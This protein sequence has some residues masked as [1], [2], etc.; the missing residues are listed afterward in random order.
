MLNWKNIQEL[1]NEKVSYET[2]C[3]V[4]YYLCTKGAKERLIFLAFVCV[5]ISMG[6]VNTVRLTHSHKI[7]TL[8]EEG[9]QYNQ[10]LSGSCPY[11]L[12]FIDFFQVPLVSIEITRGF[13]TREFYFY[14]GLPFG[15]ARCARALTPQEQ[16]PARTSGSQRMTAPDSSPDGGLTLKFVLRQSL[17]NSRGIMAS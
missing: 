8:F 11:L 4:C 2:V 6:R 10:L 15:Q 17:K 9:K 5:C 7:R 16:P 13:S 12:L 1:L 14:P 3:R